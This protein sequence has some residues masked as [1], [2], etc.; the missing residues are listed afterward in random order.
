[1]AEQYLYDVSEYRGVTSFDATIENEKVYYADEDFNVRVLDLTNKSPAAITQQPIARSG[2]GFWVRKGRLAVV[3]KEGK[4]GSRYPIAFTDSKDS[5]QTVPGTG[6]KIEG[7]SASLGMGGSVAIA[8]DKTAFLAGT[9]GDSIGVGE[10]L[11][12]LTDDGWQPIKGADGKPILGSEVVT[13]AGFMALKVRNDAGKT[14][15]GY[16]TYGQRVSV[17]P[18]SDAANKTPT[19]STKTPAKLVPLEYAD[20]NPYNAH[21]EQTASLLEAYLDNEKQV[22][23][24]FEQAFGK[25]AGAKRTVESIIQSLKAAGQE[26]LIDE[27]KRQSIYVADADRPA[28]T[29]GTTNGNNQAA[30]RDSVLAALNGQW[31]AIRFSTEGKDLP[32]AAIENLRLTF[33][34]GKYVMNMGPELQTGTYT[35][36]TTGSPMAMTINIGNGDKKGQQRNGSFKLLKDNRLLIVFATNEKEH[37]KRFVPDPTGGTIMAVYQ[38]VK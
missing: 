24:A 23:E 2:N 16:A 29:G 18:M 9:P 7:T 30:D 37:P 4:F 34:S 31:K 10:R 35:I 3:T 28:A 1:M 11:Q 15:I 21:D 38:R 32:D 13:S 12:V 25:E 26:K 5:P 33:A 17:T 36:E 20:D 19:A 27:Y 22:G 14:V 6:T 8:I